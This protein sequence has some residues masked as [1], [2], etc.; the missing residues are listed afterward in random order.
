MKIIVLEA[1]QYEYLNHVL[2]SYTRKGIA[3][4]ELPIAADV[5]LRIQQAKELSDDALHLGNAQLK[6]V[7]PNGV[8]LEVPLHEGPSEPQAS[9]S[10]IV[11]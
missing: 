10:R 8:S 9:D 11:S 6:S 1:Q 2:D 7:G 5:F 3:A 4:G